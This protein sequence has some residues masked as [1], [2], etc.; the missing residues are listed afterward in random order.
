MEPH[1]AAFATKGRGVLD[2]VRLHVG[3]RWFFH[4]D[5]HDFYPSVRT[6]FVIERFC[7]LGISPELAELLA[8]LV[9]VGDQLPQGAPTSASVGEITLYPLDERLSR[10]VT[11]HKLV[12]TRYA[13]DLAISGGKHLRDRFV[14][15]I[16][17][18]IK[19]CGW[20]LNDKGGLFGPN[21]RHL[22]LGLVV[23]AQMDLPDET[24]AKMRSIIQLIQNGRYA[25][26]TQ[27]ISSL[28]GTINWIKT[29][30]PER[31]LVLEREFEQLISSK[32]SVKPLSDDG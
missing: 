32:G 8:A 13:D 21:Q 23:N 3:N 31:G 18:I 30:R 4:S 14:P 15:K 27:E 17:D 7:T 25:P 6:S 24:Y 26:I 11:P 19:D 16:L 22:L 9:T 20:R 10:L 12:Y 28:R 2:A 29:V 5:I 1:S